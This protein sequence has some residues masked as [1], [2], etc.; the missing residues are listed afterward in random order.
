M[1]SQTLQD[2]LQPPDGQRPLVGR[3]SVEPRRSEPHSP[4]DAA[5]MNAV[6]P[7]QAVRF[8]LRSTIF[9]RGF[10]M[11]FATGLTSEWTGPG[12]VPE[13]PLKRLPIRTVESSSNSKD[14]FLMGIQGNQFLV[15][16]RPKLRA[17][18]DSFHFVRV[19][20]KKCHCSAGGSTNRSVIS[21]ARN[22]RR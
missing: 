14:G 19:F 8:L 21:I 10:G 1:R 3:D 12:R 22:W 6:S 2:C 16:S 9:G 18:P 17:R 7:P 15:Q 4:R 20:S 13:V 11:T 5:P